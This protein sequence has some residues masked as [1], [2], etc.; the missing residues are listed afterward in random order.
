VWRNT[1]Q[2]KRFSRLVRIAVVF[3]ARCAAAAPAKELVFS[4]WQ[5]VHHGASLFSGHA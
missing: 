3:E 2:V 4:V 1:R 5:I